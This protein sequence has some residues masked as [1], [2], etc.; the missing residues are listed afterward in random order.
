MQFCISHL[1]KTLLF[2]RSMTSCDTTR[3]AVIK[4]ISVLRL[5][6]ETEKELNFWKTFKLSLFNRYYYFEVN[7]LETL[8]SA[9]R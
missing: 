7:I 9:H 4:K 1:K 5:Q 8:D 2:S 6:S 3:L